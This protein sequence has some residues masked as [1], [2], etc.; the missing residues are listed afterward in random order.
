V[1]L[2]AAAAAL[3]MAGALGLSLF[4]G[5]AGQSINDTSGVAV[6]TTSGPVRG[7]DAVQA[8]NAR[9]IVA[10]AQQAVAESGGDATAQSTAELVA[11]TTAAT[12]S[13]LH[14]YAN[15]LVPASELV[16]GDGDPPSGADRDSVGL[17]Q[18]RANWGPLTDRMDPATSTR[19]FVGRLVH[20]PDWQALPAAVAAQAVQVS[21]YPDRYAAYETPA[22]AWLAEIQG[23]ATTPDAR[24][25]PS[26]MAQ[27]GSDGLGAAIANVP[28]GALPPGYTIPTTA[29][30]PE[31]VAVTFAL[32]QLGKP[33]V[34]GAAGPDAYD[35]SGLTMAA[36]AAAGVA[37][38]HY[39]V[40]QGKSGTPV[41][42]PSLLSPGDLVLIPGSDGSLNPPNPQHVGMYIGE[43]YVI[44]SPQ[45]NEVVK[46]VPLP[47]FG[48]IIAMR[49][50]E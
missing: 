46:L 1:K 32:A 20:V 26:T 13:G 2:L 18:Q 31:R 34:F 3:P 45:T 25:T 41:P 4:S 43:G 27:C 39:T 15:P 24:G 48:P 19:L 8:R 10:V 35:C 49:H 16:P 40:G 29:T 47:T 38:P 9:V 42:D 6:C 37:L 21:A 17:F 7:L 22:E 23:S 30:D 50:L 5:A 28:P 33:Y 12:E 36:W 44:E 14:D 11:L